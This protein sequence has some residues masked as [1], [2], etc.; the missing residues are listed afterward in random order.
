MSK[1]EESLDVKFAR[2]DEKLNFVLS[3]IKSIKDGTVL[4]I[5]SLEKIKAD[6][7]ELDKLQKVLDEDIEK[8]VQAVENQTSNTKTIYWLYGIA[9]GALY[10]LVMYGLFQL[11]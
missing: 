9:I 3:E 11:K 6:R 1:E 5:E 8:R 2:L 4:R 7:I 10:C